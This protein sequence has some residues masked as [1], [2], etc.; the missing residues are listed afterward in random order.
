MPTAL[1]SAF[2]N[3]QRQLPAAVQHEMSDGKPL[4]T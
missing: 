1:N 3:I 2:S 4:C